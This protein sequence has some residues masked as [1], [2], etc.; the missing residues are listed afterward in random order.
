G[1][2]PQGRNLSDIYAP[3]YASGCHGGSMKMPRPRYLPWHA[4]GLGRFVA[5]LGQGGQSG[6]RRDELGGRDGLGQIDLKAGLENF[7]AVL[8]T[9]KRGERNGRRAAARLGRQGPDFAEQR[10]AVF[11][12]HANVTDQY[13]W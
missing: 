12:G 5:I 8:G 2:R 10:I 1:I 11:I 6:D 3:I 9:S 13:G 7:R 4:I